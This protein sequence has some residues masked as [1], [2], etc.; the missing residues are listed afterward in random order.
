MNW[1]TRV[2]LLLVRQHPAETLRPPRRVVARHPER[3]RGIQRP[4]SVVTLR[5]IAV[6]DQPLRLVS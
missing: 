5:R 3:V 2:R 1:S 4:L 6:N